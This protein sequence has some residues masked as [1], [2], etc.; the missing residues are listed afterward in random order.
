MFHYICTPV[1]ALD[2]DKK[3]QRKEKKTLPF[4]WREVKSPEGKEKEVSQKGLQ[5]GQKLE[6]AQNLENAVLCWA[7]RDEG[8]RKYLM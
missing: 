4:R 8:N 1:H 3:R 2:K 5:G 7:E 6:Q